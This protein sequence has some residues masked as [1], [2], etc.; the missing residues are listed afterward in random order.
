[1]TFVCGKTLYRPINEHRWLPYATIKH[2]RQGNGNWQ[3]G[4]LTSNYDP[5]FGC[6]CYPFIWSESVFKSN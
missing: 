3:G 5:T 4:I 2:G 6:L 1:M